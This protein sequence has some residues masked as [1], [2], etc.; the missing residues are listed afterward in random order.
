MRIICFGGSQVKKIKYSRLKNE[1]GVTLVFVA[2][3]LI[4]LLSVGALVVDLGLIYVARNQLQNAADAGAL[5]GARV[6]YLND[7][8]AVN[9][10]ANQTAVDAAVAND[11]DNIP[12]GSVVALRGHWSFSTRKFTANEEN[13][14][15]PTLWGLTD[16]QLDTDLEFINAVQVTTSRKGE[17]R[18][19]ALLS[20][21]LGFTGFEPE[22]VAVA[23]IGFAGQ[24]EPLG[25]DMPIAICAQALGDPYNCTVG[26]L[27]NSGGNLASSESGGW[28]DFGQPCAGAANKP[29]I[30][31][32]VN[33]GCS[34]GGANQHLIQL[35]QGITMNNGQVQSSFT[36]LRN[37]WVATTNQ[38]RSWKLTLPVIDCGESIQISTCSKV[39]GAV[40][41]EVVWITEEGTGQVTAPY[42]MNEWTAVAGATQSERWTSFVNHFQLK[43][44]NGAAAPLDMKTIYFKPECSPHTPVGVSGGENFGIL[45]K[46]PVLV[47]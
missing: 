1:R 47:Q 27:I 5:A 32:A 16:V 44:L 28:T 12:E 42:S 29:T 2:L 36:N 26:R 10:G 23:Y 31:T 9:P 45:A 43:N 8:T 46:I 30:N 37:C 25:V 14:D 22:A 38:Q 13:T 11:P 15:P 35:G 41:V 40:E 7:G 19:A 33:T 6:L 17:H 24:L 21:L 18:V 39:V 3:L 4:V 34:G 20:R